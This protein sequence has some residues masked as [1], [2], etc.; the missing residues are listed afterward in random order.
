MKGGEYDV[1]KRFQTIV[2]SIIML[3]PGVALAQLVGTPVP[4]GTA[5]GDLASV[6][7]NIINYAL[8]IVGVVALA[9]L[10]Y[11]G[12]RYITSAGNETIIEDAKKV[13]VNAVIGIVVIGVAAALVNFVVRGVGG[14]VPAGAI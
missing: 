9:F 1:N 12:F 2:S 5:R 7:L 10:I 4:P 14:N 8:A 13:I 6:I 3:V 11:G